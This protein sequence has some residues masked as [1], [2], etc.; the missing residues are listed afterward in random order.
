MRARLRYRK[1]V[2]AIPNPPCATD[3]GIANAWNH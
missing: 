1:T 3:D 2:T